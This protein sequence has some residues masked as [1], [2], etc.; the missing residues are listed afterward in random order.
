MYLVNL[1]HSVRFCVELYN[2]FSLGTCYTLL[3]FALNINAQFF[4]FSA[5]I[6][7]L[8][9]LWVIDIIIIIILDREL[10]RQCPL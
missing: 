10:D 9:L 4:V 1:L 8:S 2:C 5:L 7:P 6:S 3:F